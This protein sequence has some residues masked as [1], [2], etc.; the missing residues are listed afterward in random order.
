M[1]F[2]IIVIMIE[3]PKQ[4]LL[5]RAKRFGT[6]TPAAEGGYTV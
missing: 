1:L 3:D 5:D 2:I 4:K 6:E